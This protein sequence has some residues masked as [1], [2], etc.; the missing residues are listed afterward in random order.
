MRPF[1]GNSK[2]TMSSTPVLCMRHCIRAILLAFIGL[3]AGCGDYAAEGRAAFERGDH[4]VARR[5][6][7]VAVKQDSASPEL[8]FML[9][10]T[11]LRMQREQE[12]LD[13]LKPL[14]ADASFGTRSIAL[15][16]ESMLRRGETAEI[17]P[18]VSA[19]LARWPSDPGTTAIDFRWKQWKHDAELKT[20]AA[21]LDYF[22]GTGTFERQLWRVQRI[23]HSTRWPEGEKSSFEA[24]ATA[25][26]I[27][28][29][30]EL[31]R[32]MTAARASAEA[33][34]Q[35]ALAAVR[36]DATAYLAEL[37][38]ITI[39]RIRGDVAAAETRARRVLALR[40]ESIANP[41]RRD[42]LEDQR[43]LAAT[44]VAQA[45]ESAGESAKAIPFLEETLPTVKDKRYLSER[46]A[47][48][49]YT[50][51]ELEKLDQ[52]AQGWL[53]A[54]SRNLLAA[55]YRGYVLFRLGRHQDAESYLELAR[56]SN[57]KGQAFHL[58]SAM[59]YASLGNHGRAVSLFS[60][61][62]D[63]APLDVDALIRWAQSLKAVD[64]SDRAREILRSALR[65]QFP[66][67]QSENHRRIQDALMGLYQEAGHG[68][69]TV[70]EARRLYREDATNTWVALRLAQLESASGAN[71]RAKDLY[72]EV[73]TSSAGLAD[74]WRVG[75]EVAL[76]AHDATEALR[77]TE[78]LNR[79]EP[80]SA[81]TAWLEARAW[82]LQRN[83]SRARQSA[84][85]ALER[86]PTDVA[87]AAILVEAALED[88]K[89]REAMEI[90]T[91][92]LA[93]VGDSAS[94][95][96]FLARAA[97]DLNEHA[98]AADWLL[99]AEKCEPL[100]T[101]DRRQLALALLRGG[102]KDEA[103][104]RTATLLKDASLAPGERIQLAEILLAAG[105]ART[106]SELCSQLLPMLTKGAARTSAL[107]LA[108]RAHLAAQHWSAAGAVL[109]E[110]RKTGAL[111]AAARL[112]IP[113]MLSVRRPDEAAATAALA[114]DEKSFPLD[115][116][117]A[118]ARAARDAGE[119]SLLGR[120][121]ALD[122]QRSKIQQRALQPV[123]AQWLLMQKKNAEAGKMLRA[124]LGNEAPFTRAE[125]AEALA[126]LV[127]MH[128]GRKALLAEAPDLCRHAPESWRLRLLLAE[129]AVAET[130]PADAAAFL[131]EARQLQPGR[132]DIARFRARIA[133][134]TGSL[135][136]ALG[137]L[138]DPKQPETRFLAAML[139]AL[140]GG[141]PAPHTAGSVFAAL[142]AG[143]TARTT[144]ALGEVRD[145]PESR[146]KELAAMCARVAPHTAEAPLFLRSFGTALA[147]LPDP[148]FAVSSEA[149]L[150]SARVA[151]PSEERGLN[152]WGV[153]VALQSGRGSEAARIIQQ[154]LDAGQQDDFL[155]ALAAETA[156][157]NTGTTHLMKVLEGAG[158]D[159]ALPGALAFEL[160]ELARAHGDERMAL[161]LINRVATPTPQELALR[162]QLLAQTN[163]LAAACR[164][165]LHLKKAKNVSRVPRMVLACALAQSGAVDEG[166]A[167][168]REAV[169]GFHP[170]QG[171]D[172]LIACTAAA[173]MLPDPEVEKLIERALVA[174]PDAAEIQALAT[175]LKRLGK[176]P[177]LE[178]RLV[179]LLQWMDP[180]AALR[181]RAA[182]S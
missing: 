155:L 64:E 82:L 1:F 58:V 22:G 109:L 129:C 156:I 142:L 10:A 89:P 47:R 148:R 163:D 149:A 66:Q 65:Q 15:A 115:C 85:T 118:A 121:L 9:G 17:E 80:T 147:L 90:G 171:V 154:R 59:N 110:L 139:V 78:R 113:A 14:F 137:F 42:G 94:L 182:G 125:A 81:A 72:K 60:I 145:L 170:E 38:L 102:R 143:E 103:A 46:L 67:V 128:E 176:L 160:A 159:A 76:A 36:A 41:E 166:A 114:L 92:L 55:F 29:S 12:A 134:S 61:A 68:I 107:P 51:N 2:T 32:L 57:A 25:A 178:Q 44:Q 33:L 95:L 20:V 40:P 96:R 18:L 48:L 117:D 161:T 179:A 116:L 167:L 7:E 3:A 83:W 157:A 28:D 123:R 175:M 75:A 99:R 35:S 146:R 153:L 23:L 11:L 174:G 106:A 13:T 119:A 141:K 37:C 162:V 69:N 43:V 132:E 164:S 31:L 140:T 74:G 21:H 111:E 34:E 127:C 73:Q 122:A 181:K 138:P 144:A 49:Y 104:D 105:D 19:A 8:R 79:L 97:L 126:E 172:W 16:V 168:F 91:H 120:L 52:L 136:E 45:W 180:A 62:Q 71:A 5:M 177:E 98:K 30:A 39:D 130:R 54:D 124:A 53:A 158:L 100:A 77:C 56:G 151:L 152:L 150:K 26:T 88:G 50:S 63:L 169:D 93:R 27:T 131:D 165:A 173:A 135:K 112:W 6:L 4:H 24:L 133:M 84:L 87:P 108:A 101:A 86:N 70:D